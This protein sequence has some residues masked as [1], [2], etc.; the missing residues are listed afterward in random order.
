[1][2]TIEHYWTMKCFKLNL[3]TSIIAS[4]DLQFSISK[5]SKPFPLSPINFSQS[6]LRIIKVLCLIIANY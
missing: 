6:L 1:M 4:I 3:F 5:D 2:P